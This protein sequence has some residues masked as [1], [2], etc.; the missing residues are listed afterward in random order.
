MKTSTRCMGRFRI[1]YAE[2]GRNP[3]AARYVTVGMLIWSAV[4]R[5]DYAAVE[6]V[7]EGPMFS[8][9]P[10]GQEAPLYEFTYH[11][12]LVEFSRATAFRR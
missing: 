10:F 12:K 6:Y 5:P 11:N 2:M 4:P 1:N 3:L 7:A 8:E 9:V